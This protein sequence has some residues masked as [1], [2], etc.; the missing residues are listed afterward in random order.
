M[1]EEIDLETEAFSPVNVESMGERDDQVLRQ[2]YGDASEQGIKGTLVPNALPGGQGASMG[3]D[4][5]ELLPIVVDPDIAEA[6]YVLEPGSI[7]G[8]EG[9]GP[10]PRVPAGGFDSVQ[11]RKM[12]DKAMR[13]AAGQPTAMKG[14]EEPMAKKKTRRKSAAEAPAQ[15]KAQSQAAP[16]LDEPEVDPHVPK[17]R[18]STELPKK[19]IAFDFGPPMGTM[20]ARYHD[21]FRE[22][23]RLVLVWDVACV[24]ASKYT[25]AVMEQPIRVVVG[26]EKEEYQVFSLGLEFT[27]ETTDR[28]YIVLMID[29]REQDG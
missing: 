16:E 13:K 9:E 17:E 20:E 11:T 8:K 21:I 5:H 14:K 22:G 4:A 25:P 27:D 7:K 6:T 18:E 24:N 29:M 1:P 19:I 26:R 23:N 12:A 3:F 2:D 15:S 28:F 10:R